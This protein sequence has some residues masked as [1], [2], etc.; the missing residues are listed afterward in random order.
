MTYTQYETKF[1]MHQKDL[2]AYLEKNHKE[3]IVKLRSLEAEVKTHMEWLKTEFT[4]I[5]AQIE[6]DYK[7]HCCRDNF[8][9]HDGVI[10]SIKS[11][12]RLDL[13]YILQSLHYITFILIHKRN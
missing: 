10:G 8:E 3:L 4:R 13:I 2:I 12:C 1:W 9:I 11:I 5:R 6:A 7:V